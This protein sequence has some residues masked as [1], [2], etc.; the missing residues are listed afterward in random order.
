MPSHGNNLKSFSDLHRY[1]IND[2]MET[3][4]TKLDRETTILSNFYLE[5]KERKKNAKHTVSKKKVEDTD[6]DQEHSTNV[7]IE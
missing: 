3:S 6:E 5:I 4:R 1:R 7:T 2:I